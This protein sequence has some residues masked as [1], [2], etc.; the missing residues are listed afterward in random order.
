MLINH[1]CSLSPKH[2]S[3]ALLS[4]VPAVSLGHISGLIITHC[5]LKTLANVQPR[6][7]DMCQNIILVCSNGPALLLFLSL[8][9]NGNK[10]QATK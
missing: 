10:S 8:K 2:S 9:S 4:Y 6:C 3:L 7:Q 1:N 5:A